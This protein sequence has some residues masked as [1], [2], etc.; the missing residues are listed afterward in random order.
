MAIIEKYNSSNPTEIILGFASRYAC[1]GDLDHLTVSYLG[2][3]GSRATCAVQVPVHGRDGST[4]IGLLRTCRASGL[5]S[6][7]DCS[8]LRS[9]LKAEWLFIMK[10]ESPTRRPFMEAKEP[11]RTAHITCHS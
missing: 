1:L 11:S 6:R 10:S 9:M 8:L 4:S 2:N 5:L 7:E 3:Q